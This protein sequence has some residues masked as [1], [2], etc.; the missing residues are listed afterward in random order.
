MRVGHHPPTLAFAEDTLLAWV[1]TLNS[2]MSAALM[3]VPRPD[4]VHAHDWV[5]AWSAAVARDGLGL[6]MVATFHSTERGRH[7]GHLPSGLSRSVN[8][9]E[10]WL[11][12]TSAG[13]ITCS[14]S[15]AAEVEE[16]FGVRPSVIP[17]GVDA[18]AWSQP[19]DPD[20]TPM[21]LYA[22]RLEW[23]KGVFDLVDAMPVLRR[24]I[25]GVRL[26][27]AGQGGQEEA[28]RQRVGERRVKGAVDFA[29]H[30]TQPELAA[31][32]ARAHAVVVPS[33]Y[34]PFGIVAL[35]AAAAGA[36]LV[37]ARTGG[38]A[39]L[40]QQ[41]AAA[42]EF[43]PGDVPGLA[44]TIAEAVTDRALTRSRIERATAELALRYRWPAIASAT[45]AAYRSALLRPS[46]YE[47]TLPANPSISAARL[48]E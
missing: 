30:V 6:P 9:M 15:M 20:P 10:A 22:G 25:P 36:P 29:G 26:I 45:V 11:S 12:R 38:L 44:D 48:R 23:E 18:T 46:G 27:I 42:A 47:K 31:L 4:L 17:N 13:L 5:T 7:Q 14:A 1:A 28:L 3:A 8:E 16:Q 35:E 43:R 37:L 24:R 2:A 19:R 34:E 41:G 39:E 21:L 32:F 40:A 33:R